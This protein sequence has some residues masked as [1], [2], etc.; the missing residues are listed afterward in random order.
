M[1]VA[2]Q[3]RL[4]VLKTKRHMSRFKGLADDRAYLSKTIYMDAAEF[5]FINMRHPE[6][7]AALQIDNE[8]EQSRLF[9][10]R[11]APRLDQIY[12]NRVRI[13]KAPEQTR[14]GHH[15]HHSA[16]KPQNSQPAPLLL[17]QGLFLL[18]SEGSGGE[19]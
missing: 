19:E 15:P 4:F 3:Y 6:I 13:A 11:L 14:D 18:E 12:A 10:H 16:R 7:P 17:K 5:S 2:K 1:F 9:W 8:A